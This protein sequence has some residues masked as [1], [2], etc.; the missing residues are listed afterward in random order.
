MAEIELTT[1]AASA[2]RAAATPRWG[3]GDAAAGWVLAQIGGALAAGFV[4]GVTGNDFDDLSL[5]WLA[6][7]QTGL[8]LGF[9]VVPLVV[10][11]LK[12]NGPVVDLGL[13]AKPLDLLVG[14]GSGVVTQFLL[15]PLVY[16]PILLLTDQSSDDL[17]A[18]AR[19]LTDRATDPFGV[20]MLVL[21]VGLAA[22]IFEEL[23]YRGLL[24]RALQR[25]F[26]P[27]IAVGG[28]ALVFG[29]SH[30]QLLQAPGL[31]LFGV[32][33][34]VLAVKTGRLGPSIAAHVAFNMV[35]VA[36]LLATG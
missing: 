10:T 12:G 15:L 33:V 9:L 24:Q 25:R 17:S 18:P 28:T 19:D 30:F 32:V 7:A 5:G 2:A 26:G 21:I 31:V 16:V 13:R 3:L 29:F 4:L 6:V 20:V 35:S 1:S 34:G 11:K 27:W 14:G 8:W 36:A 22:P 23:F